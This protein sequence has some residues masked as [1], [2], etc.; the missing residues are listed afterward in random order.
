[1]S[2][3]LQ[4][5][6]S[7]VWMANYCQQWWKSWF[8]GTWLPLKYQALFS[9]EPNA[10]YYKACWNRLVRPSSSLFYKQI[11]G[12]LIWRKLKK[13]KTNTPIICLLCGC[14]FSS[15]EKGKR[16]PDSQGRHMQWAG[17]SHAWHWVRQA[18]D[19]DGSHTAPSLDASC[20][21]SSE[22]A[23]MH[24]DEFIVKRL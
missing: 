11:L 1:M 18:A 19:W 3:R 17:S 14:L 2:L 10:T 12:L 9:V 15:C 4:A 7:A 6:F 20:D 16:V 23:W 8:A 21:V 24:Q 5:A 22:P 13:K